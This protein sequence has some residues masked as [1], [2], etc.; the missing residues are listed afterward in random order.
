MK[1]M[2]AWHLLDDDTS[3][4]ILKA[5]LTVFDLFFVLRL[6]FIFLEGVY[7]CLGSPFLSFF[8]ACSEIKDGDGIFICVMNNEF[9][10]VRLRKTIMVSSDKNRKKHMNGLSYREI[11]V[12]SIE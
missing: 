8:S 11:A 1:L 12:V 4:E 2:E 10:L 5:N 9:D 7:S 6:I 3:F